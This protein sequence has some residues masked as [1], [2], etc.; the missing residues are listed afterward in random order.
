MYGVTISA[1]HSFRRGVVFCSAFSLPSSWDSPTNET[2]RNSIHANCAI[3]NPN[4]SKAKG[5]FSV[6]TA[7]STNCLYFRVGAECK[8]LIW[9]AL[10]QKQKFVIIP[11]WDWPVLFKRLTLLNASKYF[12]NAA[13]VRE[14]F[15]SNWHGELIILWYQFKLI[16]SNLIHVNVLLWK[17]HVDVLKKY[18]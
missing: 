8:M 16:F 7:P 17:E 12:S 11:Q 1:K 4:I 14:E 18:F 15:C 9:L 3:C 2:S 5:M 10:N 6:F 13:A